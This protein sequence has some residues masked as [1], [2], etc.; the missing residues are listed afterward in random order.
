VVLEETDRLLSC[1]HCRVKLYISCD[2]HISY[3]IP[4]ASDVSEEIF[5]APYWRFKGMVFSCQAEDVVHKVADTSQLASELKCL[6]ISLGFRPQALKL[7]FLSPK[8]PGRFL[9]TAVPLQR[10]I[11]ALQHPTP[12][13]D[14]RALPAV[15]HCQAFLGETVSTIYAPFFLEGSILHDAILRRPVCTLT[16]AG[17]EALQ[18]ASPP[19]EDGLH[20]MATLCP[21]CGWDLKGEKDTMVL[22]CGNCESTWQ[23]SATAL[24]RVPFGT[25]PGGGAN[26]IHLPFWRLKVP[27]EGLPLR[28]YADLVRIANLP[29]AI[30]RQW[31]EIDCHLWSPAFKVRPR[32]FLQTARAMTL[33]Q[34]QRI[35]EGVLPKGEIYP[36][37]FPIQEALE[38]ITVIL[39]HIAVARQRVFPLLPHLKI[40]PPEFLL[41]YLPF[42]V[43]PNEFVQ[44]N[45]GFSIDRSTVQL[46]RKL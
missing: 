39:A 20:F 35:Q 15:R 25:F 29:K 6:P 17:L 11:A 24:A 3:F 26:S 22:V 33:M 46:G 21:H 8:I 43:R 18:A 34:P 13:A 10:V 2:R 4:P 23:A 38:A 5:F 12:P 28:S 30:R 42:S 14:P 27:L 7:K 31:E 45:L 32:A 40:G 37:T 9:K 41:A 44:E 1:E 16:P 19:P 36:V